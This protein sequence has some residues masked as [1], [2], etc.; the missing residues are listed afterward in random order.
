MILA[1]LFAARTV[2]AFQ[3]QSLP[4]LGPLVVQDLGI[5]Y[6][7]FGTLVGLFMLPGVIFAC[8]SAWLNIHSEGIT[9][10]TQELSGGS[11]HRLAAARNGRCLIQM[12]GPL[13]IA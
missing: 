11:D 8:G 7:V 4:A 1:V 6:A 9:G 10:T 13:N 2:V 12:A 5:D 3:F